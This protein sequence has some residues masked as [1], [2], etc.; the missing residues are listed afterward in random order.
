MKTAISPWTENCPPRAQRRRSNS[1]A[2]GRFSASRV[3]SMETTWLN[4]CGESFCGKKNINLEKMLISWWLNG[5][6]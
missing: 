4:S 3:S 5:G 1:S 2:L 6:V